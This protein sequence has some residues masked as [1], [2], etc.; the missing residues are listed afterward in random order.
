MASFAPTIVRGNACNPYPD[1]WGAAFKR[2]EIDGLND[3][4][5][6]SSHEIKGNWS[7]LIDWHGRTD[8]NACY[9]GKSLS[10]SPHI[11]GR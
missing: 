2:N 5:F 4:D 7:S 11:C 6:G 1:H 8:S 3:G 9:C 10:V